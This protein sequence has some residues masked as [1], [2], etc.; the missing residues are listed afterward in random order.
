[1]FRALIVDDEAPARARLQALLA[2]ETDFEVCGTAP[3][4]D[5]AVRQ[6]ETLQPDVVFL[7][8]QMPK[9][10]GFEVLRRARPALRPLVVFVTAHDEHALRAFDVHAMDYLLK[11]FSGRR[12]SESLGRI[13]QRLRARPE[14][15]ATRLEELLA[16]RGSQDMGLPE[17]L[18][19]ELRPNHEVLV[20][21]SDV[22][23]FRSRR[24]YVELITRERSYLQRGTLQ[25]FEERLDRDRYLRINRSEIVLV[26]AVREFQPWYRG[27]YRV[28]MQRGDVLTWSRLFR[29]RR[30]DDFRFDPERDS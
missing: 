26:D 15:E 13:R 14:E 25:A 9:C 19:V 21:L 24:N 27:D 5:L 18:L 3:D 12:F 20:R 4:G 7:D 1:M 28:L 8:V 23:I 29:A 2:C 17:R 10:D 6:L 30:K 11:P 16:E 22:E